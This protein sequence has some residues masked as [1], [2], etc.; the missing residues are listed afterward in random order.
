M[1]RKDL[2]ESRSEARG[3]SANS[4]G[5]CCLKFLLSNCNC[6]RWLHRKSTET[7]D[8]SGSKLNH[9]SWGWG[10]N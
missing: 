9:H 2:N 10:S 5:R 3:K 8:R 6:G 7:N 1:I 4:G